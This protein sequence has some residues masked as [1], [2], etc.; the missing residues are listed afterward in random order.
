M[1][2]GARV[3]ALGGDGEDN[4]TGYRSLLHGRRPQAQGHPTPQAE[5]AASAKRVGEWLGQGVRPGE[6]AVCARFTTTLRGMHDELTAAGIPTAWVRDQPGADVDGVRLATMH[7]MK[8]LEFRCVA[9]VGV[10]AKTIPSPRKSRRP[11]WTRCNT[12]TTCSGNAVCSSSPAP[13]PARTSMRRGAETQPVP[14]VR[15]H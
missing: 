4:L 13:V 1:L 15:R 7:A 8:G 2:V 14:D 9:M 10:N 11:R 5:G 3:D 6:I 12:T